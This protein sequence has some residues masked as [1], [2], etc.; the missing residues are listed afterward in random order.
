MVRG[1]G[2]KSMV[3]F[4]WFVS[5]TRGDD[6]ARITGDWRAEQGELRFEARTQ[7]HEMDGEGME[8]PRA[9]SR[10]LEAGRLRGARESGENRVVLMGAKLGRIRLDESGIHAGK[11]MGLF[12]RAWSLPLV[13]VQSWTTVDEV[14]T[15]RQHRD[16]VVMARVIELRHARA[17]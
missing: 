2:L 14:V 12:G 10:D 6:V 11:M 4:R 7:G 9:V 3:S 15:S 8:R 5:E 13:Q 16:G 17:S 1:R